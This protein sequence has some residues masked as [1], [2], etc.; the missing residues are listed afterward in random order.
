MQESLSAASARE[1]DVKVIASNR[2]R[3]SVYPNGKIYLLN[4]DCDLP[5]TVRVVY[6]GKE[7]TLTLSPLEMKTLQL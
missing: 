7:S 6:Q 3:Y 2:L 4:T 1:C 5:I